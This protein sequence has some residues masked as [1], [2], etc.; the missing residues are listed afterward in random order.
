MFTAVRPWAF[1]QFI[2]LGLLCGGELGANFSPITLTQ[3]LHFRVLGLPIIGLFGA[4]RLHG[5]DLF[6]YEGGDF[7]FL[8]VGELEVSRQVFEAVAAF[9]ARA[10]PWGRGGLIGTT[11]LRFAGRGRG[12]LPFR[13]CGGPGLGEGETKDQGEGWEE[14]F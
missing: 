6:L 11:G 5:G 13:I 4:Q 2:E 1:G 14:E 7:G 9:R 3:G 10:V 12:R 8:R